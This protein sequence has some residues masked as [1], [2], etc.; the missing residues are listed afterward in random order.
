MFKNHPEYAGAGNLTIPKA[1]LT[2][3]LPSN[4]RLAGPLLALGWAVR[5]EAVLKEHAVSPLFRV[6]KTKTK[7]EKKEGQGK[8]VKRAT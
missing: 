4:K 6:Q 1:K 8:K 3:R 7:K 5:G 2:A